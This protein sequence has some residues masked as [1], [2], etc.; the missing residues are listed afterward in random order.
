[1]VAKSS[2]DHAEALLK[3]AEATR[4]EIS[5]LVPFLTREHGKTFREAEMELERYIGQFIQY[6]AMTTFIDGRDVSLGDGLTGYIDRRPV[7]V[8]AAI[9][10]WNF[11][12][13]LLVRNWHQ[14]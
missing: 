4:A 14:H 1:M 10:P 11:P 2:S 12:A 6:A 13:S 9:I 7:G 3:I 5:V 8:V